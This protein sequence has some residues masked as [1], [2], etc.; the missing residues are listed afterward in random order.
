M[1][2]LKQICEVVRGILSPVPK[3][4]TVY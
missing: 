2:F 1:N 4:F 3:E